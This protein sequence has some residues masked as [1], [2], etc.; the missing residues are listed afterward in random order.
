MNT[1]TERALVDS[2][3]NN[4]VRRLRIVQSEAGKYRLIINLTWK[5]GD[6]NLVTTRKSIREWASL[7]RLVHHIQSDYGV[8]PETC[9]SIYQGATK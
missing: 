9:L 1:I 4:G 3:R 2:M 8:P 7:D 6:W 5:A